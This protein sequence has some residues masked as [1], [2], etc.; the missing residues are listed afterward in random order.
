MKHLVL[1]INSI[2]TFSSASFAV[3]QT[4]QDIDRAVQRKLSPLSNRFSFVLLNI[5]ILQKD[6]SQHIFLE[7]TQTEQDIDGAVQGKLSP[8]VKVLFICPQR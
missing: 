7:N 8:P 3:N 6:E 2:L 5:D 4:E 1:G